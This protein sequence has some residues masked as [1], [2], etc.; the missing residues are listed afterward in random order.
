MRAKVASLG[1]EQDEIGNFLWRTLQFPKSKYIN[2]Q[3]DIHVGR[4]MHLPPTGARSKWISLT[5]TRKTPLVAYT[6][7]SCIDMPTRA[8]LTSVTHEH[9]QRM[10][11]QWDGDSGCDDDSR[12]DR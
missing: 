2:F 12:I 3:M 1:E 10:T 11:R 7:I 4:K 8:F 9:S 6:V 5:P